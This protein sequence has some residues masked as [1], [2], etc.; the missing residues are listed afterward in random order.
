[1]SVS[2]SQNQ[3]L[4]A[5]FRSGKTITAKEARA[6]FGVSSLTSR[7]AELRSEGY[8]IFSSKANGQTIYRLG[9]ANRKIVAAA[10]AKFGAE[11][12]SE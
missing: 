3:K 9:K 1:M 8:S 6:K 12:F 2:K 4:V 5:H 10:Y 7:V 11:I